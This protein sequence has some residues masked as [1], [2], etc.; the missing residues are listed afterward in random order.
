M[1]RK[2]NVCAMCGSPKLGYV[3]RAENKSCF[4][5]GHRE[6][7]KVWCPAGTVRTYQEETT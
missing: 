7:V 1:N 6:F 3:F 5:C 4:D 2:I